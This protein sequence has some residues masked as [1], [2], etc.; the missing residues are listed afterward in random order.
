[1]NILLH[2]QA[3]FLRISIGLG[4]HNQSAYSSQFHFRH[5]PLAHPFPSHSATSL[6]AILARPQTTPDLEPGINLLWAPPRSTA[7][8]HVALAALHGADGVGIWIDARDTASTSTLNELATPRTL[9][10]LRISR[11]WTAYQHHEL[12][13]PAMVDTPREPSVLLPEPEEDLVE[14][15][16]V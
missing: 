9:S 10:R 12:V 1:M 5:N 6:I 7:L 2:R 13:R 4:N 14:P 3:K 11:S 15:S 16:G 8:H